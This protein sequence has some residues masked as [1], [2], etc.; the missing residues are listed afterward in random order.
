MSFR[1]FPFEPVE[2]F[3][4]QLGVIVLQS[5]E[6]IEQDFRRLFGPDVDLQFS[7]IRS[8]ADVTPET[9]AAMEADLGTS[10]GL[11]CPWTQFGAIGYGCTS[12]T[13]QIGRARVA[14]LISGA[15]QTRAV[16][17]PV[18]ALLAACNALGIQRIAFLSPY[19]AEVSDRICA[20][21]AEGGVETPV[22]GSFNV[23]S[24]ARVARISPDSIKQA[25]RALVESGG[26]DALFMSCTNLRALGIIDDLEAE[27]D[28]PVMSSNLVMAWDMARRAEVPLAADVPGRLARA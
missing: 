13:A 16:T 19:L 1:T 17:E 21:L 25:A 5:D 27:L 11:L 2:T 26:V 28:M 12:G 9:L 3:P 7:R 14:E 15:A 22:F 20:V 23:S 6:T 4:A 8:G 18:S 24:E 10:A